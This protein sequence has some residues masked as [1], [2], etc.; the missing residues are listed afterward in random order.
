M[1]WL[2]WADFWAMGGY[3]LYVWGS[4]LVTF[5]YLA[6]ELLVVRWQRN[7]TLRD[8]RSEP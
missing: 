5:A 4:V 6:I 7:A 3:A 1:N 2:A 8:I